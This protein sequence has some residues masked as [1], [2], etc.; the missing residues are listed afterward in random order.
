MPA[1]RPFCL[2]L[3][4]AAKAVYKQVDDIYRT[5]IVAQAGQVRS[6]VGQKAG[7]NE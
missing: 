7:R 3:I 6:Q 5:G 2:P 4:E 1:S